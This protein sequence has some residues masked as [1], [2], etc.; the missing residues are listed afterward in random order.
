M[1]ILDIQSECEWMMLTENGL[2]A[3]RDSRSLRDSHSLR[4]SLLCRD[5]PISTN[6][7]NMDQVLFWQQID[8]CLELYVKSQLPE[9]NWQTYLLVRADAVKSV[10]LYL[11]HVC[12]AYMDYIAQIVIPNSVQ[13]TM[14]ALDGMH[15][16]THLCS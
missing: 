15:L 5:E 10:K 11:C 2:L 12:R 7:E 9:L 4:D 3:H 16:V 8:A 13:E 14:G 1:D 6:D